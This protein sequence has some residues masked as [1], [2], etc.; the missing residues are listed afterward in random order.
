[1]ITPSNLSSLNHPGSTRSVAKLLVAAVLLASTWHESLHAQI[2][3]INPGSG[4]VSSAQ[5]TNAPFSTGLSS[6]SSWNNLPA[7]AGSGLLWSNGAS[8]TGVSVDLGASGNGF[9]AGTSNLNFATA[10]S[11]TAGLAFSTLA[12]NGTAQKDSIFAGAS[13]QNTAVGLRIGGLNAGVYNVY[14]TGFNSAAQALG[15]THRFW[16]GSTP[17]A[18]TLFAVSDLTVANGFLLETI[19]NSQ[20]TSWVEGVNYSQMQVTLDAGEYLTVVSNGTGGGDFRGFLPIV[21]IESV[22]EPSPCALIALG[23]V[24]LWLVQRS[25]SRS[26]SFRQLTLK[27]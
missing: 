6:T 3:L 7:D 24:G 17:A 4:T 8:A 5:A 27:Q 23:V 22:P 9:S 2:L 19:D 21:Q 1:M 13:G 11:T 25:R 16:A 18:T 15:R 20:Q 26:S 12:A 10:P 14:V